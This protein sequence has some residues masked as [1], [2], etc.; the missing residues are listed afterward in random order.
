MQ[1]LHTVTV[2][3]EAQPDEQID[4]LESGSGHPQ[5]I[6]RIAMEKARLVNLKPGQSARD[7]PRPTW[8]EYESHREVK[9][10][11]ADD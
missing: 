5:D 2:H 10:V 8:A 11:D 6:E 7:R 9:L 1:T 4:V 3:F